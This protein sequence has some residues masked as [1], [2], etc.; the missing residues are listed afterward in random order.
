MNLIVASWP[1]CSSPSAAGNSVLPVWPQWRPQRL[2][3]AQQMDLVSV[4]QIIAFGLDR[5]GFAQPVDGRQPLLS[6]TLRLRGN[7]VS[8]NRAAEQTRRALNKSRMAA[9]RCITPRLR[10]NSKSQ[11]GGPCGAGDRWWAQGTVKETQDPCN[12]PASHTT[13]LWSLAKQ[14]I[15]IIPPPPFH[16]PHR[17]RPRHPCVAT[18]RRN[19]RRSNDRQAAKSGR[20]GHRD[21]QR[22]RETDIQASPIFRPRNARKPRSEA[23]ALASTANSLLTGINTPSSST[24]SFVGGI[25]PDMP[26]LQ[27]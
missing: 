12:S 2:Y 1:R 6:M 9:N 17:P 5:F 22:S 8:L 11:R 26:P 15:A 25:R 13:G 21:G 10:M 20:L 24:A 16:L 4:A 7:A 23:A 14:P 18:T 27:R 19:N 3:R